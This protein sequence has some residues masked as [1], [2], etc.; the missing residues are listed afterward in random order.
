MEAEEFLKKRF[1]ELANRSDSE[2]RFAFTGFL[3]IGELASFYEAQ[4]QFPHVPYTMEG[5]TETAE[6]VM[7]RF[8]SPETLGYEEAFPI[9]FLKIAPRMEKYAEALTHRDF[10]GAVMSLGI[11][12]EKV[13]DIYTDGSC[14]YAVVDSTM[15]EYIVENLTQI[16]HTPVNCTEISELPEVAVGKGEEL[17][18]AVSSERIDGV[19]AKT[20]NLSRNEVNELFRE[21]KIFLNGRLCENNSRLLNAGDTVTVRGYGRVT[22]FEITGVS[23]KGKQYARVMKLGRTK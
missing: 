21:R 17:S 8:G 12:R 1:T 20:F 6:R 13:G 10:L 16:R 18:I 7:V 4:K 22:F 19:I 14:A 2:N 11:E 15:V 3:G 9:S 23:R 5:G